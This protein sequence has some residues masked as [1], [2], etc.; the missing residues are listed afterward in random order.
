MKQTIIY[1]LIAGFL[2]TG[3]N[4]AEKEAR[5]RLDKVRVMLEQ[6][7][8]NSAKNEIDS[9]RILYPKELQILK[10]GLALKRQVEIR[11]AERNIVFCDSLLPLRQQE[12]DELKKNFALEKDTAYN[13]WGNYVWKQQTIERNLQRC[14]IRSGVN[15]QGEVYLASVYFGP[16]PIRHTGVKLSVANDLYAETPSIPYDGGVN[17][18][19][20]DMGNTT[21]VVTYKGE[22]GIPALRFI[23]DNA[24]ER[25]KAEYT[26]GKPY[27][28]HIADNDR[29]AIAATYHLSVVLS[30]IVRMT[31]EKQKAEKRIVYLTSRLGSE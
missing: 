10:E 28:I 26:G 15:E 12:F 30:D 1:I 2:F 7:Q 19:F 13:E 14:Y 18:R 17:Y 9:L 23:Y 5:A 24:N 4:R 22:N 3:C 27:L 11:E 6:N 29:K 8:F 20:E 21:E 25:I 16:R 31:D